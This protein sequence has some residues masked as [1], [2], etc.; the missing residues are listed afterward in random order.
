MARSTTTRPWQPNQAHTA[1]RSGRSSAPSR[2]P[3]LIVLVAA[4]WLLA[5]WWLLGYGY[6]QRAV[7]V[8]VLAGLVLLALSAFRLLAWSASRGVPVSVMSIG[9]L[10]VIAPIVLRY[11]YVDRVVAAYVNDIAV[12]L[13]VLAAGFWLSR[14]GPHEARQKPARN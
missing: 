6:A 1:R 7:T 8:D 4:L 13:I 3:A 14:Q 5:A 10:L 2:A 12:G 9:M 11:G